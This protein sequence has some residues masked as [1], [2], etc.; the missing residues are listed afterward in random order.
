MYDVRNGY[1]AATVATAT[2]SRL[3]VMLYDRL[4]L[5]VDRAEAALRNGDNGAASIQLVHAQDIV[6]ELLSS[7]DVG[8][9]DGAP[10]LQSIYTYLLTELVET[11][12]TADPERARACQAI[13]APL[14]DAWRGAAA[15]VSRSIVPSAFAVPAMSGE[16]GVG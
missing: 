6:S 16:L 3:L 11:N 5:D 12:M 13:I 2:P 9:W 4:A 10:G 7:L 1:L 15:D 14:H 8:T